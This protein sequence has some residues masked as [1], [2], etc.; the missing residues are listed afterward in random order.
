MRTFH[1]ALIAGGVTLAVLVPA[2]SAFAAGSGSGRGGGRG[3]VERVCTGD[4]TMDRVQARDGTGWRHTLAD[5]TTVETPAT[6]GYQ[7]QNGSMDGTGP[8]GD[9]PMDGTGSQ[10]RSGR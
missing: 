9:R 8:Q 2:A 7:Y 5:G 1:K 6:P 4:Q 10:W 3:G